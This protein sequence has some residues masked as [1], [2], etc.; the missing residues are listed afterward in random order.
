MK[1]EADRQRDLETQRAIKCDSQPARPTLIDLIRADI[2]TTPEGVEAAEKWIEETK[3][4]IPP[5]AKARLDE[6]FHAMKN[7]A[8]PM[9]NP[10]PTPPAASICPTCK[11]PVDNV[12]HFCPGYVVPVQDTI[13]PP[14]A[15]A[16]EPSAEAMAVA[17]TLAWYGP[18]IEGIARALDAYAAKAVEEVVGRAERACPERRAHCNDG[19][20]YCATCSHTMEARDFVRLL[21]LAHFP[22]KLLWSA[23]G[24]R[25]KVG[26]DIASQTV[27]ELSRLTAENERLRGEVERLTKER[28]EWTAM[29][30]KA[31][32]K[33]RA[34]QALAGGEAKA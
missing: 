5:D 11:Q 19:V 14:V 33:D 27:E 6:K 22:S 26:D 8:I 18:H 3:F 13:T 2:P 29:L 31:G 30:T 1:D 24:D 21:L 25:A 9:T 10:P 20:L 15:E 34:R 7:E 23:M 4:E 28:E 32:I 12:I 16:S 17:K